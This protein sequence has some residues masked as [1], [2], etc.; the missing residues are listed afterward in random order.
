VAVEAPNGPSRQA[1]GVAVK[2]LRKEKHLSLTALAEKSEIRP[3]YLEFLE[4]GSRNPPWT[5]LGQLSKGLG[6]T[7]AELVRRAEES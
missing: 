5:V 7:L 3:A 6:V 4:G 2:V 1:L